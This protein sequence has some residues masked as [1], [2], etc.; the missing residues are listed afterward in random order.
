[1][2]LFTLIILF[3]SL[4]LQAQVDLNMELIS[5]TEAPIGSNDVW[6]FEHSNGIEY[7]ILGTR[8]NTQV[9]SLENP[10]LPIQ[11]SITF[12]PI[13]T[14]RDIKNFNDIVY[15]TTDGGPPAA[16]GLTII[17]VRDPENIES[18]I[19]D[20]ILMIGN[21]LDTLKTCHNIF[22]D[23]Q[24]YG[25]LAGCNLSNRGVIILDLFTDPIN[26]TMVGYADVAYSH[27]VYVKGDRM[28]SSEIFEGR[29]GVYDISDRSNPIRIATQETG[30]NFT[31]N[32]WTSDDQ[33]YLFTTDEKP[34]AFLECYDISDL[35]DIEKL[36]AYRP[37]VTEG[38]GVI[39]H[40]T[41]YHEGFLHTSWYSDG[42]VVVDA[43]K[44]DNLVKVA[45][46]DTWL[47]DDGG[48]NGCW[49][50]YPFLP[51]GLLLASDR[52]NGL[53][54]LR[55]SFNRAC[56][57]EGNITSAG[58]G[59]PIN[60][61]T[62]SIASPQQLA[63][64][65]TDA[66]GNYKTGIAN[67]GTYDIVISHPFY[68]TIITSV[69][70]EHG[71]VTILDAQM[72]KPGATVYNSTVI[73]DAD[74]ELVPDAKLK[75]VYEDGKTEELVTNENG[76]ALLELVEGVYDLYAATWG[77]KIGHFQFDTSTDPLIEIRLEEGYRDEF[78]FDLGWNLIGN[79]DEGFF[80]IGE[81][82]EVFHANHLINIGSDNPDDIGT[83]ALLTG[84]GSEHP[85]HLDY[86]KDGFTTA[87][88]PAMNLNSYDYPV[89]KFDMFY[90]HDG[91]ISPG[92]YT[93]NVELR[94]GDEKRIL[95]EF[96]MSDT[97]WTT[98]ELH[99]KD[100]FWD[101]SNVKIAF[102]I[103]NDIDGIFTELAFDVF[104][105]VEGSPSAIQEFED[106]DLLI[107]PNP[108]SDKFNIQLESLNYD[109]VQ[110]TNVNGQLIYSDKINNTDFTIDGTQLNP[111]VYFLQL[112]SDQSISKAYKI[113]KQ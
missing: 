70:L 40:N 15:V 90:R 27:D 31:H 13:T 44:P 52:A 50:A 3:L 12:G 23:D 95:R 14:W 38:K 7:A 111:G 73:K 45:G 47:G 97:T 66:A 84:D 61:A 98:I 16:T 17:D 25:Y 86:V 36:D 107:Y 83:Q 24:G 67:A 41:H 9:F 29:F 43:H 108:F 64:D 93:F 48:F 75:V 76:V 60:G 56:Y 49:G 102:P 94:R 87:I 113:I 99:P 5:R 81:P 68:E 100:F 51:S 1:M 54:V 71:E 69:E 26:P 101:L 22:I 112:R 42:Y 34:N 39:P 105:V 55:P 53:H 46:Y 19:W 8:G 20:P 10:S 109:R 89:V 30:T 18:H 4:G 80:T 63:R 37:P 82:Q 28:Y 57:L 91:T 6:G 33:Q 58:T 110:L 62:I 32:T 88:S 65:H 35:S 21:T 74:G 72:V 77:Y 85:I 79:I 106:I 96:T 92:S 11:K 104:E 59:L 78:Y 2:R 103:Y